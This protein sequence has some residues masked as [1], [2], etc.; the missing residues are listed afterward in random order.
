[1]KH[2]IFEFNLSMPTIVLLALVISRVLSTITWD[3]TTL[4]GLTDRIGFTV[5]QIIKSK[6]YCISDYFYAIG[7]I[8]IR[9][10]S[11]RSVDN[12]TKIQT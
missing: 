5:G 4:G 8:R 3:S 1:M 10:Q 11:I 7:E 2:D 12:H 9:T 6:A